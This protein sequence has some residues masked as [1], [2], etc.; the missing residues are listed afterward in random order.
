MNAEPSCAGRAVL[1]PWGVKTP[2]GEP[3]K[4]NPHFQNLSQRG[5]TKWNAPIPVGS[6]RAETWKFPLRGS[7]EQC[8]WGG[9]GGVHALELLLPRSG[10]KGR[11]THLSKWG[12]IQSSALS[13]TRLC[14]ESCRM[15]ALQT[16]PAPSTLSLSSQCV[17]DTLRFRYYE[18]N[19]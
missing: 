8:V 16:F 19:N 14:Y 5:C 13:E 15:W 9:G 4:L 11:V 6:Q 18:R 7:A 2:S 3:T 1:T 12:I 10:G 17:S